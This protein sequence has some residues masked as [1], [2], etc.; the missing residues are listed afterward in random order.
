[1]SS[2]YLQS[3]LPSGEQGHNELR[4]PSRKAI[5]IKSR[6]DRRKEKVDLEG[7]PGDQEDF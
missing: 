6:L 1:M 4:V 7:S 5:T 2:L 3:R